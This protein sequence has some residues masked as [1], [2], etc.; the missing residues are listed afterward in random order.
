MNDAPMRAWDSSA[1]QRFAH[2]ARDGN[3]LVL[4]F[5]NGDEV[6]L[7]VRAVAAEEPRD[8]GCLEVRPHELEL[9]LDGQVLQ[10][11]WT[12]VRAL[13]DG[14]FAG[15]L[16]ERADERARHVGVRLRELRTRSGL[17]AKELAERAGLS[18]QS[19]S[20]IE[21]GRH[22]V[23][24]STL[25]RLLAA[26]GY[27]LAELARV[28]GVPVEP[29][30]VRSL[31]AKSGL[32]NETV[33]RILHGTSDPASVLARVHRIF[34][35]SPTDLGGGNPPML[36]TPAFAGRFKEH[37]RERR[38]AATYVMYAHKVALLAEQAAD[39]PPYEGIPD[40]PPEIAAE[41][42][43][44][45]GHVGFES[46]LRWC[47]DRGVVVVPMQDRGQFHGACWL[48][49]DRPVVVL[50]QRLGWKAR[51]AFDLGHELGHVALHL[52]RDNFAIVEL[53][54]IGRGR[55]DE[56]EDEATEF[57]GEL[58]LGDPEALAHRAASAA[59]GIVDA[60]KRT[61]P[62][63]ARDADVDLGVLANYMA[64]RLESEGTTER[65]WATAGSL[66]KGDADAH[67]LAR[68]ILDEHLDWSRLTPDDA[69]VLAGAL[70]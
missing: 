10:L 54:V 49:G 20:R 63:V 8:W 40:S 29:K 35:W 44:A 68:A 18:A 42:R 38:A 28:E 21:R 25:E 56:E 19:L 5:E 2:A 9:D 36:G 14:R 50:K 17:S 61:L 23:V 45:Y 27:D 70:E 57:A 51:W 11:P 7:A 33:D 62:R 43:S 12:R 24:F 1:Y 16:A 22:D 58:L 15:Y 66:Q 3:E 13:T 4:A 60:L 55:N 37:L 64:F 26:M 46:L 52:T 67:A 53:D 39:R 59:G 65:F 31:L 30:A 47:W 32:D 48:V 34:Q 69:L 41:V 6:R